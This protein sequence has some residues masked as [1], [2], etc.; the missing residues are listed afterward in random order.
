M[1]LSEF[2]KII[3]ALDDEASKEESEENVVLELDRDM[4]DDEEVKVGIGN[5]FRS[6]LSK[7]TIKIAPEK[8]V[9]EALPAK[10]VKK[11]LDPIIRQT[12]FFCPNCGKSIGKRDKFCR[13]CGQKLEPE[14]AQHKGI[15]FRKLS[16]RRKSKN[17]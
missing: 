6:R 15:R 2:R 9:K 4:D 11:D 16:L 12:V 3:D 1:R 10:S 17:K 13:Y 8:N 5:I 14:E 7:N